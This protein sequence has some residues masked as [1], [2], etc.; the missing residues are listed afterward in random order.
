MEKKLSPRELI[1]ESLKEKGQ[2]KR[3]VADLTIEVFA[4]IKKHLK[5]IQAELS[6]ELAKANINVDMAFAERN[7]LEVEFKINDE[8][9]IFSMHT[10]VFT[11][12]PEHFVWRMPYI[13]EDMLRAN[14]GMIQ[15]YNFLTD[16]FKY[17]R[18][19][20]V[21]YMIARIFV[22]KEKHFFVE[23]KRQL[24]FL[25]NDFDKAILDSSHLEEILESTIL[26]TLNFDLLVPPYEIVKEVTLQQKQEQQGSTNYQTGKRLGFRFSADMDET[27]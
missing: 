27:K 17:G 9:I 15:V 8:L 19:N 26:Y 13:Q 3:Q 11:F 16:S 2:L 6:K 20:D 21:G 25:Y 12:D 18:N 14:C 4:D 24:G 22:N 10:N 1:I 23:G 5:K 7:P